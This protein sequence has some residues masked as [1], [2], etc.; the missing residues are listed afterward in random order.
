M[1]L[2]VQTL[3]HDGT[4][5][6]IEDIPQKDLDETTGRPYTDGRYVEDAMEL[7]RNLLSSPDFKGKNVRIANEQ[8]Q[9]IW[10]TY[11]K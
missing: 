6:A 4:I 5:L 7:A 3:K 2:T 8:N 9:T 11:Y 10:Q 1:K